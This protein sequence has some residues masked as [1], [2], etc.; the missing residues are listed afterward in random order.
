MRDRTVD[1]ARLVPNHCFA[2]CACVKLCGVLRYVIVPLIKPDSSPGVLFF[3][4]CLV[5][6]AT[7]FSMGAIKVSLGLLPQAFFFG[8]SGVVFCSAFCMWQCRRV[9]APILSPPLVVSRV[10]SESIRHPALG[11]LWHRDALPRGVLRWTGLR[12]REGGGHAAGSKSRLGTP[13]YIT[14]CGLL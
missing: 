2:E 4:A 5:T 8:F 10:L 13:S 3:V 14:I 11:D 12:D 6:G 1:Q 9:F 7:L